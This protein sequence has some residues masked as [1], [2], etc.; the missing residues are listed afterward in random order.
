VTALHPLDAALAASLPLVMA[1][2]HGEQSELA[3]GAKRILVGNNGIFLEVRS[4]ALHACL[5]LMTDFDVLPYGTV[6]PF[7]R[8]AAGPIPQVLMHEAVARAVAAYPNETAFAIVCRGDRYVIE[9]VPI[10][11]ASTGHVR[12]T[13]TLDDDALVCDFHT[14]GQHVAFFSPV[15]DASDRMRRGPYISLVLG[16]AKDVASTTLSA[17][18]SCSPYLLPLEGIT[19]QQLGVIE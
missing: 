3:I 7:I 17:R 14:H 11:S 19:L 6:H 5:P 2:R 12:Y 15:D 18:F 16:T 13:D 1:T 9:D 8:P 10:E 4:P